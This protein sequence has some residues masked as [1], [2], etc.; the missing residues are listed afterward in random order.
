MWKSKQVSKPVIID[1][2]DWKPEVFEAICKI[3]DLEAGNIR[4][5]VIR[6]NGT[7][8]YDEGEKL[9]Y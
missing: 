5:L 7:Y 9:P 8:E 1:P 3:F 6:E 4:E 2:S